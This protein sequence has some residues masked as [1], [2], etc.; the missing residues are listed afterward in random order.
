M[1]K[2]IAVVTTNRADYDQIFWL[3]SKLKKDKKID[4][5]LIVTGSHLNQ[6]MVNLLII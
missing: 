3:I 4:L 2:K 6:D 1:K 5:K